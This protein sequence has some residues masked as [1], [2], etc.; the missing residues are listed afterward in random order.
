MRP[1]RTGGL[2]SL[3]ECKKKAAPTKAAKLLVTDIPRITLEQLAE[4]L[5]EGVRWHAV[6][7]ATDEQSMAQSRALI[8]LRQM[9]W[10]VNYA[11]DPDSSQLL[12][13]DRNPDS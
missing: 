3:V 11:L 10:H 1:R 13:L 4:A 7:P 5:A 2:A 12:Y 6:L 8:A 9:Q